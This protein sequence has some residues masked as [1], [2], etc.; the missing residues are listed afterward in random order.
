MQNKRSGQL[1]RPIELRLK[2]QQQ[3]HASVNREADHSEQRNN[4]AHTIEQVHYHHYYYCEPA[5]A[6]HYQ[7][8]M[9]QQ[10]HHHY[11]QHEVRHPYT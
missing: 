5:V 4:V 7:P 8:S 2:S 1:N 11:W 9:P 10:S 6:R 3:S